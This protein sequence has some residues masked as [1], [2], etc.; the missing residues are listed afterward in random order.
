[1]MRTSSATA[2]IDKPLRAQSKAL[3]VYSKKRECVWD[4]KCNA[5]CF[6]QTCHMSLLCNQRSGCLPAESKRCICCSETQKTCL[7][8][9]HW[10]AK[11]QWWL[12]WE[13]RKLRFSKWIRQH[14]QRHWLL[15]LEWGLWEMIY[16]VKVLSLLGDKKQD[17]LHVEMC[18]NTSDGKWW[19]HLVPLLI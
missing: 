7:K 17:S 16:R 3:D 10:V 4:C 13:G 12:G 5:I 6:D 15:P 1:M 8:S 19:E 9:C 11:T 18:I 2:D 14:R